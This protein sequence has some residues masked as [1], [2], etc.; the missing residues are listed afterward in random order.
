MEEYDEMDEYE[1]DED[2]EEDK[3]WETF[4]ISEEEWTRIW[5]QVQHANIDSETIA[6]LFTATFE[7]PAEAAK[8]YACFLVLSD[9]F[10]E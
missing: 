1:L 3:P 5:K 10:E 2:L 7:S 9:E 4:G 6:D 8:A